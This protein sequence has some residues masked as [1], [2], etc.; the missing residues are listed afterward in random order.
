M[1][2]CFMV[3]HPRFCLFLLLAE[4]LDGHIHEDALGLG[5]VAGEAGVLDEPDADE[6]VVVDEGLEVGESPYHALRKLRDV[7]PPN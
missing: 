3:S 6:A 7:P 1:T 2:Y 4:G 5:A